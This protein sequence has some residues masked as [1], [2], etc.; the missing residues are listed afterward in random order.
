M[1]VQ[2]VP[3]SHPLFGELREF[4]TQPLATVER[5][6]Q[7]GD[8]VRWRFGPYWFYQANH[9][10]IIRQVLVRQAD[11]FHKTQRNKEVFREVMG[12][13]LLISD[14]SFW[15]RQRSL[16]QPAFHAGR[17][18]SYADVM[19]DQTERML[20][21]WRKLSQV[22]LGQEMMQLTLAIVARA[23]FGAELGD[24][25]FSTVDRAMTVL[26]QRANDRF[27][28]VLTAPSWLPTRANRAA[29]RAIVDLRRIV[30]GLIDERRAQDIDRGD[31]LSMLLL[32][33]ADDGSRMTDEQALDEAIT[34]FLAG[35]ETT[36]NALT[37]TWTLLARHPQVEAAARDE[38][39]R[40]LGGRKPQAADS[41]RLP[42]LM[43][44]VKEGMRMYPPA[45]IFARQATIP[46]EIDGAQLPTGAVVFVSPWSLHRDPHWYESPAE[47]R[48]GRFLG[49]AE[50]ELPK[51]AYLPFGGGPR[52][53]IGNGF[54]LLE[55]QLVM[56][57]MLDAVHLELAPDQDLTPEPMVTLRPRTS[58]RARIADAP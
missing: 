48:P 25:V 17:I 31:L 49:E 26:L 55:A 35:H 58:I 3:G 51:Y 57:V 16:V 27:R 46:V 32:A 1:Q 43:A 13:G 18:Q 45:W 28:R 50:A 56:A 47:F 37:W 7:A 54:A 11:H 20:S 24:E 21:R 29:E 36:A 23:L 42:Y 41:D 52:V 5:A 44:V 4:Q 8:L 10:E 22:D 34:L 33:E 39:R 30:Q 6:R 12:N 14:G 40:Q 9:P 15:R 2:T 53:C 19:V 38:V